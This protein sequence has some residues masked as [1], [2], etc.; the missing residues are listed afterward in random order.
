MKKI[1]GMLVM[2]RYLVEELFGEAGFAAGGRANEQVE[3]GQEAVEGAGEIGKAGVP[4]ADLF[5]LA[6]SL[7]GVERLREQFAFGS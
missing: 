4:T 6:L 2:L 3:T 7:E 5:D 1:P